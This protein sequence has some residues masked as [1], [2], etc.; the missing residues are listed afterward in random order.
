MAQCCGFEVTAT[1]GLLPKG[2]AGKEG[3]ARCPQ[4]AADGPCA[5][6]FHSFGPSCGALGTARPTFA[7]FCVSSKGG[8]GEDRCASHPSPPLEERAGERRSSLSKF[9]TGSLCCRN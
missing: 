9:P 5:S 6:E 4:R 2:A 1:C 3:R 8:E 7:A